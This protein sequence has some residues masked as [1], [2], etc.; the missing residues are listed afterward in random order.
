MDPLA[1]T[2]AEPQIGQGLAMKGNEQME[3]RTQAQRIWLISRR[4][5]VLLALV[6]ALV[7]GLLPGLVAETP[8]QKQSEAPTLTLAFT[9][10]DTLYLPPLGR[11]VGMTWMGPDTLAVLMDVPDTMSAS[12]EHEMHV[13]FQDTAG[14]VF[15][16]EDFSGVLDRALAWDGEFLWSCGDADDGSSILYKIGVDSLDVWQVEEA[17]NTPG[18]R[19]SGMCYDGRFVWIT[20]RDSGRVDRFDPE[21]AEITRSALTPGFSPFGI[22]WDGRNMWL[23]DSG[24]GQM[25]RVSGSRRT[26]SAT[27]DSESFM[28]RGEDILLLAEGAGFWYLPPGQ[29]FAVRIRFQ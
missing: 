27:V 10:L 17:Y 11:V 28:Y 15:R 18:H 13:V 6:V 5:S 24:T 25:Y 9:E 12:G 22:A 16:S 7:L 20:D 29:S 3:P 1:G 4:Q 14:V 8:A 2:G 23:T 21:V 26:W 19:P